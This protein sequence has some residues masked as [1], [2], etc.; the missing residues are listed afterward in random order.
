MKKNYGIFLVVMAVSLIFSGGLNF[1]VREGLSLRAAYAGDEWK[2]DFDDI[3]S[4]TQDAMSYDRHELTNL[5]GRCDKLKPLIEKLGDTE[6]R[7][8][9]KR[10]QRCRDLFAYALE[11]KKGK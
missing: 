9:L 7:V 11:L 6:R 1:E 10:L 5:L 2:K 4:K 3:C 8:Y